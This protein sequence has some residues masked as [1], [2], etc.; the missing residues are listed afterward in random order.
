MVFKEKMADEVR[1][2]SNWVGKKRTD[3]EKYVIDLDRDVFN[4]YE[5]K[6]LNINFLQRYAIMT[7]IAQG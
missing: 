7:A 6:T 1:K 3:I 4:L 5:E 2:N